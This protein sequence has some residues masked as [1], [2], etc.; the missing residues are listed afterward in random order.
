MTGQYEIAI[1][2][3]AEGKE[4]LRA[5]QELMELVGL[6]A[7]DI[8]AAAD[9]EHIR[10]ALERRHPERAEALLREGSDQLR[11]LGETGYLSTNEGMRALM[12]YTASQQD[13]VMIAF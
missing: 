8:V 11:R 5:V 2:G 10:Q 7:A 9:V 3:V 1:H 6:N 12:L 13:A 4:R